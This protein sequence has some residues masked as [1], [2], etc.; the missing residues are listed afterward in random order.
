MEGLERN[1]EDSFDQVTVAMQE[2]LESFARNE[3]PADEV[4]RGQQSAGYEFKVISKE[5]T[6]DLWRSLKN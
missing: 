5:N 4:L 1:M 6:I 2:Y 3:T